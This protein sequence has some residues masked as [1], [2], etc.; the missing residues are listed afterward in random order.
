MRR[1]E[2]ESA[3][4]EHLAQILSRGD[5]TDGRGPELR[6]E[7]VAWRT[8]VNLNVRALAQLHGLRFRDDGEQDCEDADYQ[9][10]FHCCLIV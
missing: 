8:R 2:T 6:V 5:D 9:F 7:L 4:V 10:H 3:V 1:V